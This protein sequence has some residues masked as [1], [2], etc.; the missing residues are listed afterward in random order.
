MNYRKLLMGAFLTSAICLVSVFGLTEIAGAWSWYGF[1][2][3]TIDDNV[4][5]PSDSVLN[6]TINATVSA[7]CYNINSGQYDQPG[8]GN[9]GELTYQVVPTVTTNKDTGVVNI[10]AEFDLG[11]FDQHCETYVCED[12]G[13][14][15]P[16]EY[17]DGAI[18]PMSTGVDILGCDEDNGIL[19][20][21]DVTIDPDLNTDHL[22][23]PIT[24]FN[25]IEIPGTAVIY[26]FTSTWE[27][28]NSKGRVL[29]SG[30]DHCIWPG[31]LDEDGVPVHDVDFIC[32]ESSTKKI[33][34][35]K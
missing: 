5:G 7:Q 19:A 2:T 20:N 1:S 16:C 6:I 14:L 13:V 24:N 28:V 10:H 33:N 15:G 32:D 27:W 4:R 29:N 31:T 11:R 18:R 8:S 34:F 30:E 23:N 12:D 21:H 9:T 35:V 25:K 26:E 22:C 17:V 3:L